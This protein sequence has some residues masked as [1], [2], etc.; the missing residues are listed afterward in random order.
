MFTGASGM[1]LT[2]EKHR[3]FSQAGAAAKAGKRGVP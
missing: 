2:P 1:D 3:Y